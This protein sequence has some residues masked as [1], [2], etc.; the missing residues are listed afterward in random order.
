MH[1]LNCHLAPRLAERDPYREKLEQQLF[2]ALPA[3]MAA[4]AI[5]HDTKEYPG[6]LWMRLEEAIAAYES[7]WG[8]IGNS[9]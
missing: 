5:A 9:K 1:E 3:L 4:K 6:R 8:P 7:K 2:D